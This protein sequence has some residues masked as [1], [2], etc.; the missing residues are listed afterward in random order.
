MASLLSFPISSFVWFWV[1]GRRF[2]GGVAVS[3]ESV[4]TA[5]KHVDDRKQ[6]FGKL[7]LWAVFRLVEN[8]DAPPVRSDNPL[9]E[10]EGEAA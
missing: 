2:V 7:F 10:F 9:N 5:R 6:V 4:V 8:H 1:F 3:T